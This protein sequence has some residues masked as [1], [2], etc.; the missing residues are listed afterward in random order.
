MFAK[1]KIIV[2]GLSNFKPVLFST[3]D[4]KRYSKT[5]RRM[6]LNFN[7][8]PHERS[9]LFPPKI[10]K[11]LGQEYFEYALLNK[12]P[13]LAQNSNFFQGMATNKLD[14]KFFTKFMLQDTRYL[15]HVAAL[16]RDLIPY[17]NKRGQTDFEN[18]FVSRAPRYEKDLNAILQNYGLADTK[19]VKTGNA[20]QMYIDF[21]DKV[22]KNNPE[23]LPLA[24]LA[25]S[26]LWPWMANNYYGQ[27]DPNNKFKEWFE[28]NRPNQPGTTEIFVDTHFQQKDPQKSR[29]IF[30]EGLI[31]EANLF[32]EAGEEE[33][34]V[35]EKICKFL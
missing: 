26:K 33:L 2:F 22:T 24:L 20:V 6:E 34:L 29:L 12:I 21:L 27:I 28:E 25:C 4:N 19:C 7:S 35:P 16:S 13:Q 5:S 1:D 9:K 8:L 11:T 10:I 18:F 31:M 15:E 32:R 3:L 23:D 30:C 14:I 17:F